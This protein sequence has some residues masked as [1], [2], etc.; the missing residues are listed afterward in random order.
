[1]RVIE[2]VPGLVAE[3]EPVAAD[4]VPAY[5]EDRAVGDR[6]EGLAELAEDVVAVMPA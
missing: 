2:L 4:V 5:G 6:E 1:M 3:P